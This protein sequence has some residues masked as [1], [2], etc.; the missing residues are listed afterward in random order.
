M[1]D[2]RLHFCSEQKSY[3]FFAA[4]FVALCN[5]IY[6]LQEK[7]D[8]ALQEEHENLKLETEKLRSSLMLREKVVCN[9]IIIF[10]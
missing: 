5:C 3:I 6:L 10:M 7:S 2:R 8:E 9:L 4:S 1:Q